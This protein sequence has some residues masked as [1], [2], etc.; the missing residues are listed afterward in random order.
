LPM[1]E[2]PMAG[3]SGA[4]AEKKDDP[5]PGVVFHGADESRARC[6]RARTSGDRFE[7]VPVRISAF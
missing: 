4:L 2:I 6:G 5:D 1:I 3:T 7:I